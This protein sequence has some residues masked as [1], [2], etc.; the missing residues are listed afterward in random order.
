MKKILPFLFILV[1]CVKERK[2]NNDWTSDNLY[3]PVYNFSD[4]VM[5]LTVELA[6][7][8]STQ[9]HFVDSIFSYVSK[10]DYLGYTTDQQPKS[11]IPIDTNG[12][13][14]F[15]RNLNL[16]KMLLENIDRLFYVYCTKGFVKREIKDVIFSLDECAS[17]IVV[18]RFDEIDTAEYGQPMFCS[19]TKLKLNFEYSPFIDD[20]IEAFHQTQQY[21]YTDNV[22]SIS[23]ANL[24][25]LYFA[26]SDD[27]NWNKPGPINNYFPGRA[28]YEL[29]QDGSIYHK[30]GLGLDLLGIPCD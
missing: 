2:F 26:Y 23:Y 24:D 3:Y 1:S 6:Y 25:S 30:W 17:N 13:F 12:E 22:K 21:D 11:C 29:R 5:G 16:E 7:T 28:V 4:N 18:F 8:T 14:K 20:K 10:V 19:K 15:Y 27:F 9:V